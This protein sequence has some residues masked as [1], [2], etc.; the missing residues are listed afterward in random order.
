MI[1]DRVRTV[2]EKG[3]VHT[4]EKEDE[5]SGGAGDINV[6][7]SGDYN[8]D[9]AFEINVDRTIN[10]NVGDETVNDAFGIN[11]DGYVDVNV[12]GGNS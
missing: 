2:N 7:V 12:D 11:K 5:Q 1:E 8:E 9:V 3:I 4:P 6:E 10:I